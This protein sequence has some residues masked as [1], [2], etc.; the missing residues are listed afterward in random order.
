MNMPMKLKIFDYLT[1]KQQKVFTGVEGSFVKLTGR[2]VMRYVTRPGFTPGMANVDEFAIVN[3]C[4]GAE[5][6]P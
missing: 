2:K 5:L 1:G 4:P 6:N 3:P